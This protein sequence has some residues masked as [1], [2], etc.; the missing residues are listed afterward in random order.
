MPVTEFDLAFDVYPPEDPAGKVTG[1]GVAARLVRLT[2][3]DQLIDGEYVAELLGTGSGFLE[4]HA[5]NPDADL[6]QKDAYIQVVRMTGSLWMAEEKIGGFF[7][8]RGFLKVL[9]AKEQAG[10]VVRWEGDGAAAALD[11]YVLGHS[12]YATGQT[13]RGSINIPGKW[14]WENEPYGAMLTRVLEEGFDHP[15]GFY[16][17]FDWDFD[18]DDDSN[19]NPWADT[20]DYETAIGT[21]GL[22]LYA[23]FLKLG[24]IAE[25]S[26]DLTVQAYRQLDEYRTD[27]HSA[28][29]AAGKVRFAAGINIQGDLLKRLNPASRRTHVLYEDRVG[30]YQTFDEDEDGNPI[31]GVPYMTYRKS[32]TTADDTTIA[33]MGAHFLTLLNQFVDVAKVRHL[34]GAG[35]IAGASGYLPSPTGDYWLGDL[36]TI[37][38]GTTELD[39]D[40]QTIEVAAIRY[41]VQGNQWMVEAELGAQYRDIQQQQVQGAISQTTINQVT[42]QSLRTLEIHIGDGSAVI[43]TGIKLDIPLHFPFT[44][45]G[46]TALADVSGSIQVDLWVDTRGNYPPTDADSITA[47]D[48]IAISSNDDA[49]DM[50]PTGWTTAITPTPTASWTMR[51]NVDSC[52]SIKRV[53]IGLL[54]R[55]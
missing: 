45:L 2:L 14:H 8:G 50:A 33:A 28:T 30:D 55:V 36:V 41:F 15:V 16:D 27:R 12:V 46:W 47:S 19:G 26:P 3:D 6:L 13:L 53:T 35:G 29:F 4:I 5:D 17:F 51:V 37:H 54:V 49:E 10:R 20:S 9:S 52:T 7:L 18:R 43:T 39:F 42:G 44:I 38:T 22:K 1:Y 32:T 48:P 25:V 34:I 21:S 31:P 23:D 40:E 24:L 11:R